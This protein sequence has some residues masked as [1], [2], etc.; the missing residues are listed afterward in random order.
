MTMFGVPVE[1]LVVLVIALFGAGLFM[2]FVSGLFGIGGG[3]A[4][5]PVLYEVFRVAGVD[6][7]IR[8]HMSIGTS[9]AIMLPTTLHSFRAH[10]AKGSADLDVLKAFAP[11]LVIGIGL[12]TLIAKVASAAALTWVW[13]IAFTIFA[14]KSLFGRDDWRLGDEVPRGA[15]LVL[16]AVFTGIMSTLM[17]IG[18]GVFMTTMMTLYNRPLLQA[19]GTSS[20]IGPII[21]G[22]GTAGFIWA[23]WTIVGRPPLSLGYVNLL[24]VAATIPASLFAAPFGVRVAHGLPKR[25][26]EIGFALF[27]LLVSV[28]F[29]Y[30][31]VT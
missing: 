5:V 20:G 22:V 6:E 4:I 17:S 21:S 11:P 8:M 1:T 18:G 25:R 28:R 14:L 2:G 12:G 16:Y 9:L 27:A 19:I 23:G 30:A 24:A 15:G 10:R 29:I 13:A 26:L 7:A 31:A 3:A